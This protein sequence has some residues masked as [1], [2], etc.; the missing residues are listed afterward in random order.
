MELCGC[1]LI[2]AARASTSEEDMKVLITSVALCVALASAASAAPTPKANQGAV[3]QATLAYKAAGYPAGST[4]Q[5]I[6]D[7]NTNPENN[8]YEDNGFESRGD[9]VSTLAHSD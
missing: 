2:V 7:R 8:Y 9:E 3:A 1:A 5:V 4:G 6:S